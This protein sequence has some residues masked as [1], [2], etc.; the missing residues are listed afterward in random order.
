MKF[1]YAL[2]PAYALELLRNLVDFNEVPASQPSF[3]ISES[4]DGINLGDFNDV[5]AS[6]SSYSISESANGINLGDFNEDEAPDI[7]MRG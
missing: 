4:P 5:P 1:P 3:G 2:F 7:E 6:Q